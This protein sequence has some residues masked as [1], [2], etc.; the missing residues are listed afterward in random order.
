[1]G[2]PGFEARRLHAEPPRGSSSPGARSHPPARP[3]LAGGRNPGRLCA[4]RPIRRPAR[5]TPRPISSRWRRS[6]TDS[7]GSWNLNLNAAATDPRGR[8]PGSGVVLLE[9][10]ASQL[11]SRAVVNPVFSGAT[12]GGRRLGISFCRLMTTPARKL[13]SSSWAVRKLRPAVPCLKAR[14]PR[15]YA[16]RRSPIV[17][18]AVPPRGGRSGF[19][20]AASTGPSTC[21]SSAKC[22]R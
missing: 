4:S 18:F 2:F 13:G 9:R 11:I 16:L 3:P 14:S 1:M 7:N 22:T 8:G 12:S 6:P 5:P 19:V 17:R 10:W 21:G 20:H 15:A